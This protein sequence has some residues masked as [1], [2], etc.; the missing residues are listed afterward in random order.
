MREED[1]SLHDTLVPAPTL[2]CVGGG[3]IGHI[4]PAVAVAHALKSSHPDLIVHFVTSPRLDDR[5]FVER[6]GFPVD[7]LNAPRISFSFPWKFYR[8]V[9]ASLEILRRVEPQVIFSKGGYVSAP[10]CAAARRL[11]IP[12]VLHESDTTSGHA[13][14]LVAKWADHICTGFETT[15]VTEHMTWTGNPVRDG[16]TNGSREE[17]LRITGFSGERPI[18]LVMGGSQGA[19]ALNR[20]ARERFGALHPLCD[21]VHITGP[22]KNMMKKQ[23][24]YFPLE[25]AYE[26]LPHLYA[27]ADLAVSRAGAG[28]IAELAANGIPSLLVPLRGVAHDHQQKNALHAEK[29]GGAIVEQQ[30]NLDEIVKWVGVIMSDSSRR[31]AMSE[32]IHTL[33]RPEAARQIAKILGRYLAHP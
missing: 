20:F 32:Q 28:S 10:I 6:A 25:F 3:S 9:R 33:H 15:E 23:D 18:L 1:R 24:G 29:F 19:K 7:A 11:K 30:G 17:G 22:G 14:R 4:A 12:I 31:E 21:I 26:E 2:L 8:A 5:K 16:V 13:N 27:I